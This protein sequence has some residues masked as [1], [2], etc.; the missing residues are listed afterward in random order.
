LAETAVQLRRFVDAVEGAARP[1]VS[2]RRAG[3]TA[4]RFA[5]AG[6]HFAALRR[7][8]YG[9]GGQDHEE[10]EQNQIDT[11]HEETGR[12]FGRPGA[13]AFAVRGHGSVEAGEE[14]VDFVLLAGLRRERR[15]VEK[16]VVAQRP[17][18][19]DGFLCRRIA[20]EGLDQVVD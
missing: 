18:S 6:E 10:G 20:A 15:A 8:E 11:G 2:A 14:R 17:R 7:L 13:R 12:V 9:D 3:P 19:S 1:D 4:E 16:I 5:D